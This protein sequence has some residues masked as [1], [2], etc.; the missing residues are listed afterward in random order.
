[1]DTFAVLKISASALDAQKKRMNVIASNMANVHSTRT[2]E[3][4]P[5][6]R[7]DVVFSS[8]LMEQNPAPLEGVR[9]VDIATDNSPMKTVFDPGHPDADKE[10]FVTMPNVNVIEEMVNMMMA[11][12]AYEASVSVFNIS[13]T[14]FMKTL[15]I[16]R[17]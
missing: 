11:L 16:G 10:G 15:E 6:R 14:M 9:I 4:G 1:M 3:G 12:R 13:K 5:Y 17:Q 8:V 7:K 2:E